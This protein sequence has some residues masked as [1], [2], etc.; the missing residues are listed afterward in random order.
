[1]RSP[2]Y[3]LAK[4]E[5]FTGEKAAELMEEIVAKLDYVEG[6]DTVIREP[7]ATKE[8]AAYTRY[9]DI[10]PETTPE[11]FERSKHIL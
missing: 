11:D 9:G 10:Q 5:H 7:K 1:M 6:L 8:S 3:D 4:G 2:F